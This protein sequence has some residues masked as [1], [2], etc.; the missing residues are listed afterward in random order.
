[1]SKSQ[2]LI[3]DDEPAI[4]SICQDYLLDAGLASDT[5]SSGVEALELIKTTEY[6]A[7]VSDVFMPRMSGIELISSLRNAGNFRPMI[8]MTGM[9]DKSLSV[10]ALRLGAF[11]ILEKPFKESQLIAVVMKALEHADN[12]DLALAT[13]QNAVGEAADSEKIRHLMD[14]LAI[15]MKKAG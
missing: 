12:Q 3:V 10:Q 15:R 13:L 9:L 5:V 4:Q 6:R 2:V 8:V 7:I 14:L 11:D 1:M